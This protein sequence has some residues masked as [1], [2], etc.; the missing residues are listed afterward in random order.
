MPTGSNSVSAPA[1]EP[2]PWLPDFC[3]LPVL[4]ALLL[5]AQLVVLI[6]FLAPS[7]AGATWFAPAPFAAA[8]FL[9]YLVALSSA[10]L[11]CRLRPLLLP[12]RPLPGGLLAVLLVGVVAAA[13]AALLFWL[14]ASLETRVVGASLGPAAIE[15]GALSMLV[16]AA[17]LRYFFVREQWNAQVL[18]QARS[19]MDA[20]QARINPHFLFNSMNTIASLVRIDPDLAERAVEDLSDLFRAALGT[21]PGPSTLG[22]EFELIRRYLGIEQLR[23]GERLT[24]TW[25][26]DS[27]PMEL[28]VPPLLL[29][30]LVENAVLHGI[31][32]IPE[33]GC[34]EIHGQRDKG[35][36][37]IRIRNPRPRA[38]ARDRTSNRHALDNVRQ[39]IAYHYGERG[40]LDAV[41]GED[42]YACEVRLPLP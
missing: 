7:A 10:L 25:D 13:I 29:Q 17:A 18:A 4:G 32:T 34:I 9:A 38:T 11:L 14:D 24:V 15:T 22:G 8:S 21:R 2:A 6:V 33:G 19:Q 28:E 42:Y 16:A 39:R 3:T 36:I 12:L 35:A 23:L 41:A 1:A 40:A 30:P 20:L 5:M 31:Q 26:V 37:R 27:L